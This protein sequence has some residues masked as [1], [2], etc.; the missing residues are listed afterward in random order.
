MSEELCYIIG[1]LCEQL[2]SCSATMKKIGRLN[3]TYL[4]ICKVI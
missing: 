4:F 2:F 3:F 1:I